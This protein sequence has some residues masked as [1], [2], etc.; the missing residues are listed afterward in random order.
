MANSKH[1]RII[2][3]LEV[4]PYGPIAIHSSSVDMIVERNCSNCLGGATRT[5]CSKLL[6]QG[7]ASPG[8]AI[9]YIKWHKI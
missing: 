3:P 4:G 7:K 1:T 9:G 8:I 2:H 6:W 5:S